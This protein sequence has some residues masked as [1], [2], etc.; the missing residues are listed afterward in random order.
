MD[1]KKYN[2]ELR[3]NWRPNWLSSINELTSLDLQKRSWLDPK[4]PSPHWSFGEF[5]CSYFDDLGVENN[6]KDPLERGLLSQQEFEILRVWH[7][8]LDKYEAPNKNN[9]AVQKILNDSK[10]LA[11]I[12][13]GKQAKNNL[14]QIIDETERKILFEDINYLEFSQNIVA[15]KKMNNN[16]NFLKMLQSWFKK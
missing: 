7:E 8:Q 10:W 5:M 9:Y 3:K 1:I 13:I 12:E 16:S 2:E 11:I 15:E 6:Y 4:A 14:G